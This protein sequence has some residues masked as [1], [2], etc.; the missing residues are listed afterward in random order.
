MTA[1][2]LEPS[3]HAPCTNTTLR[4]SAGFAVCADASAAK[5]VSENI[6]MASAAN[7]HS[8]FNVIAILRKP[9]V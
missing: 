2:Q 4:A 8:V 1:S 9:F 6:L 5:T 7:F 3:A